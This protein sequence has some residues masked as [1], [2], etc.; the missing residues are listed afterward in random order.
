[1]NW[2]GDIQVG[3]DLTFSERDRQVYNGKMKLIYAK[4]RFKTVFDYDATFGR[5]EVEETRIELFR[6][7][8]TNVAR[9][10]TRKTTKTD[11]NRMNGSVKTDFDLTKKWYMYNLAGMGYDEIRQID[12]RYEI[13]PGLGYHLIKWTNFFVNVEAGLTYQKEERTG[14]STL[15]TFFGRLAQN[16]AWKITPRL[17]WDEKFEYLP[18]MGD[19]EEFRM[20]IETNLRYAMLQNVFLNVSLIDTYDA[21]A[22]TGVTRND[23]QVRS[24]VGVKF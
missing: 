3:V 8:G 17:T 11:A 10:V 20:R 19:P 14:A 1:R 21:L 23:V 22:A 6:V 24:S 16:A 7:D 2:H 15:S 18:R 9:N 5:S 4:N 12:M 13:G